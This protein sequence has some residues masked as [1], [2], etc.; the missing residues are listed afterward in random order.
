MVQHYVLT[1]GDSANAL[2]TRYHSLDFLSSAWKLVHDGIN[3][4]NLFQA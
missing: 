1:K 2:I 3:A 4:W